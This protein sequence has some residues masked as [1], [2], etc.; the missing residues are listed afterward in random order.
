MW[1]N[2]FYITEEMPVSTTVESG[3]LCDVPLVKNP[4][5]NPECTK[6][7]SLPGHKELSPSSPTRSLAKG[8]SGGSPFSS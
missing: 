2:V 3:I 8:E 5:R 4:L 7:P 1:S 6:Q